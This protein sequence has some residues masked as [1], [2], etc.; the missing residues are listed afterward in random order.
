MAKLECANCGKG[1]KEGK[2]VRRCTKCGLLLCSSCS[3]KG[4]RCPHC[5][6]GFMK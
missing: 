2:I 3:S 1:T 6:K 5:R 4:D